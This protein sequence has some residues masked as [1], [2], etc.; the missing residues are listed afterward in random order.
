M[1]T[2]QAI[3]QAVEKKA[4]N[5]QLLHSAMM[6]ADLA[7]KLRL[8]NQKYAKHNKLD[9]P[10]EDVGIQVGDNTVYNVMP[11]KKP[12]ADLGSIGRAVLVGSALLGSGLG[13]AGIVALLT[14]NQ[15]AAPAAVDTDTSAS[16]RLV[17][18]G[19][20]VDGK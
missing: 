1:A 20:E 17:I 12:P 11:D 4:L 18:P 2:E 10:E 9:L 19:G 3:H 13:G 14:K 7:E 5:S 6:S 15:P 16:V 8:G